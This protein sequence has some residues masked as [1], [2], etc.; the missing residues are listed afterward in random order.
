MIFSVC[1]TSSCFPVSLNLVSSIGIELIF[2]PSVVFCLSLRQY[3]QY[4][5]MNTPSR[6][7]SKVDVPHQSFLSPTKR[8]L[9]CEEVFFLVSSSFTTILFGCM[10]KKNPYI[11]GVNLL[12]LSTQFFS[13][14]QSRRVEGVRF[15]PQ[16]SW[17]TGS[18]SLLFTAL[19]S[20][21]VCSIDSSH[22]M[23]SEC[24]GLRSYTGL[25][26]HQKIPVFKYS[27]G[28]NGHH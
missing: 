10:K 25:L 23:Q 18:S 15:S 22:C 28:Q 8:R 7:V 9:S 5:W 16:M 21:E 19:R 14:N 24:R 27:S 6:C 3:K 26:V 1:K 11:F 20:W 2:M 13:P 4:A 17:P 12:T